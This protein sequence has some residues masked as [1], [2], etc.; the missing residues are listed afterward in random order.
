M[1]ITMMITAIITA[2]IRYIAW[3]ISIL[4]IYSYIT[5]HVLLFVMV[6]AIY[7][8][9]R[10]DF[11]KSTNIIARAI[12][13]NKKYRYRNKVNNTLAKYHESAKKSY[14]SEIFL[15]IITV[16]FI[17]FILSNHLIFFAIVSSG[18]MEPTF[19]KG[20]LVLMQNLVVQPEINDIIIF[21]IPQE[22]VPITHRVYS[23]S[24]NGIKTKG[25]AN[26]RVDSW[27][28][29]NDQVLGKAVM[30]KDKPIVIKDVANYFL[31][32]AK[33]GQVYGPEYNAIAKVIKGIKLMGSIIF[34]ICVVL[35]LML[36][37]RVIRR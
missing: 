30:I 8:D 34:I 4:R 2:A 37:I 26:P 32:E 12:I 13:W 1:M 5:W 24:D 18:S 23:I 35:Y 9:S 27:V 16:V 22:M 33:S 11:K 17:A 3:Q 20:D 28:V 19:K 14:F 21:K 36:S 7:Y 6:F 25:D 31:I 15:P 29:H 10:H